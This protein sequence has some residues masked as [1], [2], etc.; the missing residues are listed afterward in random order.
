MEVSFKDESLP[1]LYKTS[2]C[3]QSTVVHSS[4]TM[5]VGSEYTSIQHDILR[6]PDLD[7]TVSRMSI[8]SDMVR[9]KRACSHG[10]CGDTESWH[11]SI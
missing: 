1:R 5:E 7:G 4:S 10:A 8:A 11:L 9:Q 6:I 2:P 3:T